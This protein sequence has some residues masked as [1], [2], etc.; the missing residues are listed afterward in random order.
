MHAEPGRLAIV[1]HGGAGNRRDNHDGCVRA[2]E[3]GMA[4]LRTGRDALAAAVSAVVVLEDDPRFNAGLGSILRAD[5]AT[6]EMDAA[7]MDASGRLGAVACLQRTRNPVLVARAVV[8]TRHWMLA[9]AGAQAFAREHGFEDFDL[10]PHAVPAAGAAPGCDTVG[11][12]ALDTQGLFAVACSTGGS[13]PALV[14]RVGDTPIP[15]CGFW[16]GPH[17]AITATGV[18]E[19]IVARLLSRRV[20]DRVA[21][22]TPLQLALDWGIG[23]IPSAYSAG[24]IGITATQCAAATNRAMP[25]HIL[26]HPL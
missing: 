23:L 13:A 14:G 8:D 19:Q 25:F 26:E 6:I 3:A 11:A 7:V 18:G 1:V 21:D 20:Y 9:G 10:Q 15:G 5:G 24:L 2:A 16:A 12:V 22:G 17:G 4:A